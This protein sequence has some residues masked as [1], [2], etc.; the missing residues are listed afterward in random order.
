[1][2]IF[3][4]SVLHAI[5]KHLYIVTMNLPLTRIPLLWLHGDIPTLV[6]GAQK[7]HN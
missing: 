5:F 2:V 7:P 4:H 3:S 1:V 6:N